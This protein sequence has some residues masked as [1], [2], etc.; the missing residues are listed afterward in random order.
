MKFY[1]SALRE[2]NKLLRDTPIS[3]PWPIFCGCPSKSNKCGTFPCCDFCSPYFSNDQ[4]SIIWLY[5]LFSAIHL[6]SEPSF[7]WFN[8]IRPGGRAEYSSKPMALTLR[9]VLDCNKTSCLFLE[10]PSFR[11]EHHPVSTLCLTLT[12]PILK[13]CIFAESWYG[14]K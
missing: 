9:Y 7:F 3:R 4:I 6:L 1:V 5:N 13:S 8:P 10:I 11:H 14:G 12:G 2:H